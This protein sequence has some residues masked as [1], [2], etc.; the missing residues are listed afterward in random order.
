MTK[1]HQ[2]IAS[3]VVYALVIGVGTQI[4]ARNIDRDTA[5]QCAQ[6]AWPQHLDTI[7]KD[8]CVDNGYK[9]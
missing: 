8:W 6:H 2:V 9:I 7:H 1:V 3:A 4:I 5:R